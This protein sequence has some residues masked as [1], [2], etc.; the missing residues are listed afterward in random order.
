MRSLLRHH[1]LYAAFDRF[2]SRK[3]AAVHIARMAERLFD[4]M[5]GGLLYV[6]GNQDLP[7]YQREGSV[8]ILRCAAPV[9]NFLVRALHYGRRLTRSSMPMRTRSR[10]ATSGTRGARRSGSSG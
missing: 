6:L 4:V 10:C 7:V 2:P 3:G 8:E 1:A 5:G 9:P